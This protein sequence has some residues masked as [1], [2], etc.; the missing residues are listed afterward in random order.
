MTLGRRSE[1]GPDKWCFRRKLFSMFLNVVSL[2]RTATLLDAA[3]K[4]T[5]LTDALPTRC[6]NFRQGPLSIPCPIRVHRSHVE[7]NRRT[8]RAS[9]SCQSW[10]PVIQGAAHRALL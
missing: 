6:P 7:P 8:E 4:A 1:L 3:A 2:K 10:K 5:D 9:Q